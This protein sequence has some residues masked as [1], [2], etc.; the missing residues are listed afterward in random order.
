ML[1]LNNFN[2]LRGVAWSVV[3]VLLAMRSLA[4]RARALLH[5]RRLG[6]M[7]GV[8]AVALARRTVV[9]VIGLKMEVCS[10]DFVQ[11]CL[12]F[13]EN[14]SKPAAASTRSPASELAAE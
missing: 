12:K 13:I 2:H 9:V 4:L 1:I 11:I 6:V 3:I 7:E 5:V 8:E 10:D 14:N